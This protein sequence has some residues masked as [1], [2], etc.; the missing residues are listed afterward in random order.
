[1][2]YAQ[3]GKSAFLFSDYPQ[4]AGVISPTGRVRSYDE[5]PLEFE[6]LREIYEQTFEAVSREHHRMQARRRDTKFSRSSFPID[7]PRRRKVTETRDAIDG[8][9]EL[10]GRYLGMAWL[11]EVME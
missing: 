2:L 9:A 3:G 7:Q 4:A 11:V 1:M 6:S 8:T 5:V 10:F